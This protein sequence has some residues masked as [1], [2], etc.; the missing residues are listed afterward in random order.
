MFVCLGVS[1][2]CVDIFFKEVR[3]GVYLDIREFFSK[4]V[5]LSMTDWVVWMSFVRGSGFL[6]GI[7]GRG[8]CL[9]AWVIRGNF[10]DN[11]CGLLR[12][13]ILEVGFFGVY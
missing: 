10:W 5:Y 6:E 3:C 7:I 4:Y 11:S 2:I 9:E 12:E 8:R 1:G 13:R